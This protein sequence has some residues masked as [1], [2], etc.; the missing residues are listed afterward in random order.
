MRSEIGLGTAKTENL[1]AYLS[2]WH[3]VIL[4]L[5]VTSEEL[6]IYIQIYLFIP[7]LYISNSNILKVIGLFVRSD[8]TVFPG[9]P[10]C[11]IF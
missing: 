9:L 2:L 4:G 1:S 11:T 5:L 7:F 3:I 6:W 8:L 10:L